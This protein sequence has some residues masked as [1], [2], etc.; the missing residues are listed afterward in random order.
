[1]PRGPGKYDALATMVRESANAETV[2]L[3]ILG[4]DIGSGFSVQ[5]V[6]P[7]AD[8]KL[9]KLLRDTAEAIELSLKEQT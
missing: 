4:G 6:D 1:M 3:I 7:T 5:T 8:N 9:P 2:I